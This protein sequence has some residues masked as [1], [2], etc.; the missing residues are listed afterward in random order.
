[1]T[2]LG[3]V[4]QFLKIFPLDPGN[5][6]PGLQKTSIVVPGKIFVAVDA[7]EF[8]HQIFI[9][10]DVVDR[11]HHS[12]HGDG[13]AAAHR[14][15]QRLLGRTEDLAG[16][17]LDSGQSLSDLL[18][19][20]LPG[21]GESENYLTAAEH[22]GGDDEGRRYLLMFLRQ[23]YQVEPFIAEMDEV[24]G[25]GIDLVK[26]RDRVL[27]VVGHQQIE[28]SLIQNFPLTFEGLNNPQNEI[29]QMLEPE[30]RGNEVS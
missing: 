13:T 22:L 30:G 2:R 20:F 6:C 27:G 5:H 28:R 4:H 15:Q 23:G 8:L 26:Q 29:V 3:L 1:M 11:G 21:L 12:R 24:V 10:A 18:H 17:L 25:I 16:L 7:D 19:E 9:L 14:E